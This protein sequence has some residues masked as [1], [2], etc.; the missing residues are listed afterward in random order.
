[1]KHATCTCLTSLC[2]KE[3]ICRGRLWYIEERLFSSLLNPFI[4]YKNTMGLDTVIGKHLDYTYGTLPL[5]DERP[6]ILTFNC[7]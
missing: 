3:A 5:L 1:M 7:R 6:R 4:L 2:L